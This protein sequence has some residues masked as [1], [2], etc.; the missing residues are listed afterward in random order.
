MFIENNRQPYCQASTIANTTEGAAEEN[1]D[2]EILCWLRSTVG[3]TPVFGRRT[4][5]VPRRWVTTMWV[6]RPLQVNQLHRRRSD[7]NSGGTHGGTCYKSPAV[8]AKKHIFLHLMQ[9]IWCLKFCNMTKSGGRSPRSKFWEDL[10][11]P[12]PR[13]I[14][15]WPTKP[16]QPFILPG[17][18]NE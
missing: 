1:G 11:P 13:D 9:I 14:R 17:S 5:P 3:G 7:W 4:G 8:E 10:P 16:T 12:F 18:I 15:P 6:N 2:K